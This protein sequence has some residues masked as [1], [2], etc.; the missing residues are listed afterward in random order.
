MQESALNLNELVGI[1]QRDD[2]PRFQSLIMP[3]KLEKG[4]GQSISTAR[5]LLFL[6]QPA[7]WDAV[8]RIA[9]ET[10]QR[11]VSHS[12]IG[13]FCLHLLSTNQ[14]KI[15][16]LNLPDGFQPESSFFEAFAIQ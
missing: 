7:V 12:Q 11:R 16:Y 15:Q 6:R 8:F 10:H 3:A 13:Q 2:W 9:L 4:R 1:L 5:P 14:A